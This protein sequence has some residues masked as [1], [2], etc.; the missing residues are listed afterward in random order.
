MLVTYGLSKD[1]SISALLFALSAWV[2]P[3][4]M[5]S[6]A[7]RR[8]RRRPNPVGS[9]IAAMDID[10]AAAQPTFMETSESTVPTAAAAQAPRHDGRAARREVSGEAAHWPSKHAP[11]SK[12]EG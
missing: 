12:H 11:A 2:H 6:P 5:L 9:P 3:T 1:E 7:P 4:F 8:S 10:S